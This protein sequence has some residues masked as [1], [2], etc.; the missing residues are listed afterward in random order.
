M[1]QLALTLEIDIMPHGIPFRTH[2]MRVQHEA[3]HKQAV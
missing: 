3:L 1:S 2:T